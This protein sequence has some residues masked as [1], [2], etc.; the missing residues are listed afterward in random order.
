MVIPI[1]M[2][3][4]NPHFSTCHLPSTLFPVCL[5]IWA[6]CICNHHDDHLIRGNPSSFV[7]NHISCA[8]QLHCVPQIQ[9][10]Y[11]YPKLKCILTWL[12]CSWM[13]GHCLWSLAYPTRAV[14][15]ISLKCC[16]LSTGTTDR[17]E[18]IHR[19][20]GSRSPHASTLYWNS[21]GFREVNKVGYFFNK[22]SLPWLS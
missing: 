22:S 10:P 9:F 7:L 20:E 6:W 2:N 15:T 21:A 14:N 18:T 16:L 13:W 11:H 5:A 1:R 19:Y 12:R 17:Q 4:I 8:P 3:P